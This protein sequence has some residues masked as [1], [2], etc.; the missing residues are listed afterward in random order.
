MKY[1]V[2]LLLLFS[3]LP[4]YPNSAAAPKQT[5]W[6]DTAD[7]SGISGWAWDSSQ[8][9]SRLQIDLYDGSI[10]G[11]PFATVAADNYRR[12]LQQVGI[13]DGRYAF[14]VAT[15]ASLKD[16][17]TH[18]IIAAL[19]GT[20]TAIQT[21][22]NTLSC[23]ADATGYRYYFSDKLSTLS[24]DNWSIKGDASSA[25]GTALISRIA[26][27]D[28]SSEYEVRA[29]L[30][31]KE[32][33]GVYSIYLHASPDAMAG[34]AA[35][36]SFYAVELQN[37]TFTEKG[38][39]ATLAISKRSS[40]TVTSLHSEPV[41]CHDGMVLRAI[42]GA[43][44]H[45]GVWLDHWNL[46]ML[47]D[48]EV[49]AGRPGV[50]VRSAPAANSWSAVDL[51]QLDR[52]A[53]GPLSPADVQIK[54]SAHSVELS[55]PR[56]TDDPNGI[57]VGIYTISRDGQQIAQVSRANP[58]YVDEKVQPGAVYTYEIAAYDM[59]LNRT[60][61]FVTVATREGAATQ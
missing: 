57:G 18:A 59:H 12:D 50:G 4:A 34:P 38:C 29:A 48:S 40:E 39:T 16:G 24:P 52:L 43:D 23:P 2:G 9:S 15:P 5:G 56:I 20:D 1:V 25:S 36:G 22:V 26:V 37:P 58:S 6:L 41:A 31:L 13:G 17:R 28:G 30:N 3:T 27:P 61:T 45:I 8:P 49:A 35:A 11:S 10:H 32:S 21:G 60:S 19:A 44:G 51:G 14:Y 55:W 7:C 53:P 54:A 46:A 42:S 33:G 47:D